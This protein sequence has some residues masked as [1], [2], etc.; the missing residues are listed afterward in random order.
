MTVTR[1]CGTTSIVMLLDLPGRNF[2][3]PQGSQEERLRAVVK[4]A[5]CLPDAA[6]VRDRADRSTAS[7]DSVLAIVEPGCSP[8]VVGECSVA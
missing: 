4:R 1:W 7:F 6:I 5:K 2:R 3:H 8:Y